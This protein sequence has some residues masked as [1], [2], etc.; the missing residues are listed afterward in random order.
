M[1]TIATLPMLTCLTSVRVGTTSAVGSTRRGS[2]QIGLLPQHWRLRLSS[3]TQTVASPT[4]R[5]PYGAAPL[6][7]WLG[8][9]HAATPL[10]VV[11]SRCPSPSQTW[12]TAMSQVAMPGVVQDAPLPPVP[13][14]SAVVPPVPVVVPVV[15]SEVPPVP[16]PPV[17][18]I[19]PRVTPNTRLQ[20]PR[21]RVATPRSAVDERRFGARMGARPAY[22]GW[23]GSSTQRD[24]SRAPSMSWWTPAGRI[25]TPPRSVAQ[26]P[27]GQS[28]SA[29]S[30][31]ARS[32][33]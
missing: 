3:M 22:Y 32:C 10:H 33:R 25:C 12:R 1:R 7:T 23:I 31:K 11:A 16:V 19:E 26:A 17:P 6:H 24:R 13:V 15:V 18:D 20:A 27:V 28:L 21:A 14:V 29:K 4:P 5:R 2:V 8:A 9:S 30:R